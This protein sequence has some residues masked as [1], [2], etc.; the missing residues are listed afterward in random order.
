MGVTIEI[1]GVGQNAANTRANREKGLRKGIANRGEIREFS[2]IPTQQ[3]GP[4]S[5]PRTIQASGPDGQ[6]D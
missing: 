3:E 4:V 5:L 1:G 6:A 2:S